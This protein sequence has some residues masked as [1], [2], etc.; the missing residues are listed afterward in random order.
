M[1]A[2]ASSFFRPC[3]VAVLLGAAACSALPEAGALSGSSLP[4]A[5]AP[6]SLSGGVLLSPGGAGAEG[7]QEIARRTCAAHHL[8]AQLGSVG[9][10]NGQ[11][12]LGYRCV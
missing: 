11:V 1:S 6:G 2:G 8:Q 3:A 9:G 4:P 5:A 7:A 12:R 10:S